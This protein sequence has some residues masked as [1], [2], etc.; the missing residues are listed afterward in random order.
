MQV[1]VV[2][3]IL[4]VCL[5]SLTHAQW[6][7]DDSHERFDDYGDYSPWAYGG[8][9]GHFG[10]R[11]FSSWGSDEDDDDWNIYGNMFSR[12]F[13]RGFAQRAAPRRNTWG[14]QSSRRTT[15]NAWDSPNQGR[16]QLNSWSSPNLLTSMWMMRDYDTPDYFDFFG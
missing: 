1:P 14:V 2:L 4:V 8:G 11:R 16:S 3:T 6:W 9:R 10:R 7:G 13:N 15:Q 5:L 12:G